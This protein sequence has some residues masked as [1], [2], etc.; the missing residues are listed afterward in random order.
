MA[1]RPSVIVNGG[2]QAD[3]NSIATI[4]L[5][6]KVGEV[7]LHG[8]NRIITKRRGEAWVVQNRS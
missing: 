3:G 7:D 6:R 4:E 5:G 8:A 2:H 1:A